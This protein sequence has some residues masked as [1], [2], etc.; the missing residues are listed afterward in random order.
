MAILLRD[1]LAPFCEQIEIAGSLRRQLPYVGD[2]EF[3]LI[4]KLALPVQGFLGGIVSEKSVE[5]RDL[6]ADAI[7][8]MVKSGIL[9]QRKNV[10]GSVIWGKENKL[11]VYN[12][13]NIP[14]DFFFTDK[15]RWFMALAIRTGGKQTNIA[16][17]MA[18][19]KHGLKLH[20]YGVDTQTAVL[21]Q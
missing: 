14:V 17:A 13:S 12:A 5:M 8:D 21:A 9:S 16:L 10:N 20:P 7:A 2:I 15:Q 1:M 18:A 3:L 6:A 11:A 19:Q 4:P